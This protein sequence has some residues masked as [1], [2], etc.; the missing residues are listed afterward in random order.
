MAPLRIF[1]TF[2][3]IQLKSL[4]LEFYKWREGKDVPA[5]S[6]GTGPL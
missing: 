2:F 3:A 4:I 6:I 1:P 5:I